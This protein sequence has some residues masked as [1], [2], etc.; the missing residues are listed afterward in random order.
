MSEQNQIY[1]YFNGWLGYF[2]ENVN[3]FA[4]AVGKLESIV[5]RLEQTKES[6]CSSPCSV[7]VFN[8]QENTSVPLESIEIQIP[9]K[10]D[11]FYF[12]GVAKGT[13]SKPSMEPEEYSLYRFVRTA[14][15]KAQ[16]FVEDSPNA[17]RSFRNNPDAQETACEQEN[18]C[19]SNPKGIKTVEPG[20]AV[21]DGNK[22][23]I[24]TKVKIRY[25]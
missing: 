10:E 14:A 8:E 7:S 23:T 21:F 15:D 17:L 3:K 5:S 12:L 1:E 6:G 19:P 18:Q 2:I 22:W 9:K 16:V 11:C 4:E 25:I 13:F 24:K 20:E